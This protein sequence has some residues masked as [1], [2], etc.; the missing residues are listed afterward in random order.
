VQPVI[1]SIAGSDPSGGAGIQADIRT[2]T[3]NG[4]YP[5]TA[6][7]ALTVQNTQGVTSVEPVSAS[8]VAAQVGAVLED[9]TVKALKTGMLASSSIV[10][11]LADLLESDRSI[12]LVVDPVIRSS[13]GA[14]LL[15][16]AGEKLLINRLFP[17][18]DLVTP[19]VPEAESLTGMTIRLPEHAVRAG[20][21]IL[22]MGP[23]A[24]LVKG[25][26]LAG[27]PGTDV[28][29][30]ENGS[31]EFRG[32]WIDQEHTHGTGCVLSAAISTH[33]GRGLALEESIGLARSFLLNTIK[34][35][36]PTGKG[37]GPVDPAF[38][39]RKPALATAWLE[40]L[41]ADNKGRS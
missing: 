38:Y 24:V 30:T 7:T 19:N 14:E 25:G 5:A 35:A 21:A 13:S 28:L 29:V 9:L 22:A 3:A 11:A 34:H 37:V 36:W 20:E 6:I 26:H 33:L 40:M 2:I 12:P 27:A 32:E 17:L 23:R 16:A 41:N 1:L 8:L 18:A 39:T 10:A 4:G 31:R 15:D